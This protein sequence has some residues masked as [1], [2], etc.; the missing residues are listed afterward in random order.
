MFAILPSNTSHG[1]YFVTEW[2]VMLYVKQANGYHSSQI[3]NLCR[4]SHVNNWC[5]IFSKAPLLS[6]SYA[7]AQIFSILNNFQMRLNMSLIKFDP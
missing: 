2:G 1:V 4:E 6:G 3:F 7:V 5:C